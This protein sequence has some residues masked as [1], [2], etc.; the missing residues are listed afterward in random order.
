M[1]N[2]GRRYISSATAIYFIFFFVVLG[3]LTFGFSTVLEKTI[4]GVS[5][6]DTGEIFYSGTIDR[7]KVE[8]VIA[9]YQPGD[10]LL[11]RSL[12]GDL[13]AGMM[14]GNF[15][16][17]HKMSV[18]VVD[19]CVSSCANYVFLSGNEKILNA[20]S[21]VV[22]HGG[23]KQANFRSLMQQAYAESVKPGT[24][25]GREGFEA[26]ISTTEVRRR[27]GMGGTGVKSRCD[28]NEVLNMYGKCEEFGPE[29]RL[30]YIIYLE[31]E[32]YSRVSPQMDKN[33]PY[34]GQLGNYEAIYQAYDYFGFYY[35]LDSLARLG[36][37]N[38]SVKGGDWR[39]QTNPLFSQVYEVTV[40]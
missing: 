4:T 26:I 20:N 12:G 10:R 6:N 27:L 15:I 37:A 40:N 1:H 18:E 35:S 30:Q 25:F 38:V 14:L 31:D 9:L 22:F 32:L 23:P 34:Y 16:N 17:I 21:L 3:L 7:E 24:T 39:P 19:Y 28:K 5:R 2:N 29:Q 33:I 13:H 8:K 11:I 36:V